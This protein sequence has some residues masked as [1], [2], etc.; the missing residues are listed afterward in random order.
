[1]PSLENDLPNSVFSGDT[2]PAT[3][4][5]W[6]PAIFAWPQALQMLAGEL[7][8]PLDFGTRRRKPAQSLRDKCPKFPTLRCSSP[9]NL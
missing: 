9:Q 8:N 3:G 4:Q 6:P 2:L 1:M 5:V 7:P